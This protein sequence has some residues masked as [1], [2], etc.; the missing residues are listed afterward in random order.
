LNLSFND[1][2]DSSGVSSQSVSIKDTLNPSG[3]FGGGH[4]GAEISIHHVKNTNQISAVNNH[5]T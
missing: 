1:V 5:G 4:I 2:E 3:H